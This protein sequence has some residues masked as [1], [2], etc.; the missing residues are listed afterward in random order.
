MKNRIS[1]CIIITFA[2]IL[3]SCNSKVEVENFDVLVNFEL[4]NDTLVLEMDLSEGPY[5]PIT[6]PSKKASADKKQFD[7]KFLIKNQ[8]STSQQFA[9]KIYYQNESYKFEEKLSDGTYNPQSA[10]NFYGS[11]IADTLTP[12]KE[13]AQ[14]ESGENLVINDA[15]NIS[16]NPLNLQKH[17]GDNPMNTRITKSELEQKSNE[18]KYN[19]EWFAAISDKAKENN[20]TA[21]VQLYSD[22]IWILNHQESDILEN[23]RWQNN[24]RVG[25]YNFMLIVGPKIAI[26]NL[27]QYILDPSLTVDSLTMRMNPFFFF[28]HGLSEELKGKITVTHARQTLKTFAVLRPQPGLLYDEMAYPNNISQ[29][30]VLCSNSS[31]SFEKAHFK[32]F[33]NT[34]IRDSSLH[35]I[36]LKA[37][38]G[39]MDYDRDIFNENKSSIARNIPSY[40]EV[41]QTPCVNSYYDEASQSLTIENPGND[42][43]PFRKENAGIEGRYGFTYGKFTARIKFP[44]ILSNQGV[45]N[46][47]T[48]AFWLKFHSELD[49]NKRNICNTTGYL[50][51]GYSVSDAVY[52]T[53][54]Y[55]SEID[56]EIVKTSRNWPI[57]SYAVPDTVTAYDPGADSNLMVTCTNWDMACQDPSKFHSGIQPISSEN[58]TYFAHRWNHWYKAVTIKTENPAANTVGDIY[59]YQIDW[60]PDAITWRL[61]SNPA[62]MQEIAYMDSSIT[63][64]PDN[65]M[66]PVMSQEFHYG[67]WWPTTPYPQGDIPYPNNPISGSLYEIVIE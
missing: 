9:Y 18:I 23:Q 66:V 8:T 45:W 37:D 36:N 17:F 61:G 59:H 38:V 67:H 21:E 53:D 48:C 10:E 5:Y 39:G 56:I 32:Q 29:D 28:E 34:E 19:E 25:S 50:K 64:I 31:D 51:S 47:I 63:K 3:T 42:S 11:W 44:E 7:F 57:G 2:F 54:T 12:F 65:Q 24:P 52:S 13:T 58:K 33:L 46:G 40:V 49:W 62:A 22:A 20:V 43:E 14:I 30:E 16:G 55:Y 1:F 41:P 26:E 4:E 6:L 15:F 27:P 60:H 35:N